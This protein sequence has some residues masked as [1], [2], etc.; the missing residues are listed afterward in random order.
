MWRVKLKRDLSAK[1]TFQRMTILIGF[2]WQKILS[3]KFAIRVAKQLIFQRVFDLRREIGKQELQ[4]WQTR[5]R[6]A[7]KLALL[8][9][10]FSQEKVLYSSRKISIKILTRFV[11]FTSRRITIFAFLTTVRNQLRAVKDVKKQSQF[12]VYKGSTSLA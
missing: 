4:R 1:L 2:E 3:Q 12:N 9:S 8:T 11:N 6:H 7:K 5:C 10:N